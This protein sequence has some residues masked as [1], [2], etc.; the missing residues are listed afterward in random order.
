MIR[1]IL[2]GTA[3]A[4]GLASTAMSHASAQVVTT[5]ASKVTAGTY[6]VE[7]YHTRIVF[8]VSHMGFTTWYGDF[9]TASGTL[10]FDPKSPAKSALDISFPT[11]SVTTTNT[12]LDGELKS[13]MWFDAAQFPTITF[14][15]TKIVV[16]GHNKGVIEGDLTFHGVTHPVTLTAHFN[17]AGTNPLDKKYTIGFDAHGSLSRADW[18]VKTY[19]PL[20]GDK[21]DLQ[22][23]GAFELAN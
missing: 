2:L 3:I 6:N 19:E 17:G 20:I 21:V 5:T 16:T 22:L 8:S 10:T 4:A 7:P 13:P 14:K 12:K 15:S 18:G 9:T 23:S 1:K 11:A